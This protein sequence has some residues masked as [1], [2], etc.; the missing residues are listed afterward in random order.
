MVAAGNAQVKAGDFPSAQDSAMK[1]FALDG[2]RLEGYAL[3]ALALSRQGKPEARRFE[4]ADC[5]MSEG[6]TIESP[7]TFSSSGSSGSSFPGSGAVRLSSASTQ[8]NSFHQARCR[9]LRRRH[10]TGGSSVQTSS[11]PERSGDSIARLIV[12]RLPR[13]EERRVG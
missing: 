13:S 7:H 4:P 11:I 12:V 6:F 5:R 1:A 10:S 2:N 9:S 3:A 8:A